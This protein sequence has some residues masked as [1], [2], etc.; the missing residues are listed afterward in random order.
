MFEMISNKCQLL[1][2]S[3]WLLAQTDAGPAVGVQWYET[4]YAMFAALILLLV[5]SSLLGRLL[6]RSARMPEYATKLSIIVGCI[7][8]STLLISSK[9]PP[10]FGI[11]LRGG[12]NL[13][14]ELNLDDLDAGATDYGVQTKTTAKDIIPNRSEQSLRCFRR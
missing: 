13:I 10:K 5:I 8:I 14:G 12:M 11:D 9:W 4:G 2:H 1:S 3:N 7:L 6:A